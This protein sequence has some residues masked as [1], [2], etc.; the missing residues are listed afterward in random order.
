MLC[1]AMV[2]PGLCQWYCGVRLAVFTRREKVTAL[3]GPWVLILALTVLAE[4]QN[5]HGSWIFPFAIAS[6]HLVQAAGVHAVTAR[7]DALAAAADRDGHGHLSST[8]S[9]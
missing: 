6:P 9:T 4:L 3:A 2:I 5:W 8:L 7:I 1:A